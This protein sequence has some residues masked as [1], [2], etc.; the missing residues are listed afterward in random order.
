MN[1]DRDLI[2]ELALV[3]WE[4]CTYLKQSNL[5]EVCKHCGASAHISHGPIQHEDSCLAKKA[6]AILDE[7][8]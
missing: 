8:L 1:I 5:H 3:V 4:S 6:R 2:D 7:G